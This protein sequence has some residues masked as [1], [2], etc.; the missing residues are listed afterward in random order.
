MGVSTN[1]ADFLQS[2][3]NKIFLP[4]YHYIHPRGTSVGPG[5]G[6]GVFSRSIHNGKHTQNYSDR[7]RRRMDDILD[8]GE[9]NG[10]S[11]AEYRKALFGIVREERTALR[12]G[13]K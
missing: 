12:L 9:S 13:V 6:K 3:H 5:G 7:L 2:R 10:W 4:K 1:P 11:S 8:V